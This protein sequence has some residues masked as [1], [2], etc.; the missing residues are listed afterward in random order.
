MTTIIKK[1]ILTLSITAILVAGMFMFSPILVDADNKKKQTCPAGQ[2]VTG[3][4]RKDNIIC[5]ALPAGPQGIQGEQGPPGEQGPA[6]TTVPQSYINTG[7]ADIAPNFFGAATANCD[8]GDIATGG[9]GN[10]GKVVLPPIAVLYSIP[11]ISSTSWSFGIV[12]TDSFVTS[13]TAYVVCLDT[14]LPAHVP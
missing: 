10:I 8:S 13:I 3:I 7:N 4:D 14:A 12:N 1:S 11:N 9:G 5:S 2:V 6:G